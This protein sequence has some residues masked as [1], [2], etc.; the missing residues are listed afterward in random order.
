MIRKTF[1]SSQASPSILEGRS[2]RSHSIS[3]DAGRSGNKKK[4]LVKP[5]AGLPE[6]IEDSEAISESGRQNVKRNDSRMSGASRRSGPV[7]KSEL[8]GMFSVMPYFNCN[9]LNSNSLTLI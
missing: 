7:K 3:S 2:T 4:I 8:R 5:G 6:I 1:S 9:L